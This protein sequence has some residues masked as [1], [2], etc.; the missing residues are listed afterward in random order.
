MGPLSIP[1]HRSH[2]SL[3]T[4]AARCALE[5]SG[6]FVL[7]R[8][9]GHPLLPII[10]NQPDQLVNPARATTQ[11]RQKRKGDST[12]VPI[13]VMRRSPEVQPIIDVI[14]PPRWS[15]RSAMPEL[16]LGQRAS[17]AD[18]KPRDGSRLTGRWHQPTALRHPSPA[19]SW[20]T[21]ATWLLKLARADA[22]TLAPE[23]RIVPRTPGNN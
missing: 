3:V 4:E 12:S 5:A 18:C 21:V 1:P 7:I 9:I 19:Y 13:I 16:L 11:A 20:W 14:A 22:R 23:S 8:L 2:R 17:S 10:A 15:S 6:K